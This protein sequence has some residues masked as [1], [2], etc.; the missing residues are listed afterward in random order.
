[1]DDHWCDILDLKFGLTRHT[2]ETI[3]KWGADKFNQVV[4][5]KLPCISEFVEC[6]RQ[7]SVAFPTKPN[8]KEN[9]WLEQ[10]FFHNPKIQFGNGRNKKPY[11]PKQFGLTE[12]A[13]TLTLGQ[14]F[15]N[16]RHISR[17]DLKNLGFETPIVEHNALQ[18]HL[19]SHI[20]VGKT[21]NGCP[22]K[23]TVNSNPDKVMPC[24]LIDNITDYMKSLRKVLP[25]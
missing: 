22:K 2:R 25:K 5:L 16:L 11:I 12:K 13:S 21:F 8:P 24:H 19:K 15:V 1:M 10:P 20:G 7:F 3:Y 23:V 14:L 6:F 9:R 17:E 18:R 4:N